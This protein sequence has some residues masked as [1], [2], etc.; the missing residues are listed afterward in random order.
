MT[1]DEDDDEDP[2]SEEESPGDEEE[3]GPSASSSTKAAKDAEGLRVFR[4]EGE[5]R[6]ADAGA[7]EKTDPP[8]A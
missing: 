4:V 7:R 8:R 6:L 2:W 3:E 1:T 5:R